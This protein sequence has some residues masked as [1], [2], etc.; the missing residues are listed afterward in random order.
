MLQD[1]FARKFSYVR[2]SLTERCN[3]KCQYCLPDG[4][5]SCAVENPL[6]V[7]E[8][9]NLVTALV[10]LGIWKIRL[11]GGEPTLRRDLNDVLNMITQ[12]SAIKTLAITTNAYHLSPN[13]ASYIANGLT[14]LNV[15]MDSLNPQRFYE[16]TKVNKLVEIKH[17]I[18]LALQS[19]LKSVKINSV[20]TVNSLVELDDFLAYIANKKVSLRFIELMQTGDNHQYFNNNYLS[21]K[22]L[23]NELLQRGWSILEREDGAG[24]AYEYFHPNSL[25]KVGIIAPYSKDFC[26]NCNRLRFTHD[27]ALRLCLFGEQ[28]YP[29]RHLMQSAEQ[30]DELKKTIV[31]LVTQKPVAH[32]LAEFKTGNILNLSNV[33]G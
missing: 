24:P 21:A 22:V 11:T 27:G 23:E 9:R 33:G 8:L 19:N 26:A 20:L 2:L 30:C 15:S 18:D 6:N 32:K 16:I 3:F 7:D 13:L 5:K 31:S 29:L 25:G 12:F 17:S 28:N 4:Y 1:S 10:G 14:N